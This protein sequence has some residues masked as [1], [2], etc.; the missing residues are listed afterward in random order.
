VFGNEL[1]GRFFNLCDESHWDIDGSCIK[2]VDCFGSI[3][4]FTMLILSIHEH[5]RSLHFL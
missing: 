1:K 5:G 3:A 2:H 4:I